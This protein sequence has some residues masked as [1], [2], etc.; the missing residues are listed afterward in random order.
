MTWT[1]TPTNATFT[2]Q[3]TSSLL[4]PIDWVDYIQVPAT[5]S[6]T[7]L[8]LC[9]LSPPSGM[10]L[11]PAGAFTMGDTFSDGSVAERLDGKEVSWTYFG[12]L[13]VRPAVGR[14]FTARDGQ[15][16][17]PPAVIEPCGATKCGRS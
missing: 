7:T 8:Q 6:I 1:N 10:A 17:S 16:G 12:T 13:G 15:P 11:I 3:T 9:D 2:V 4:S 14:D 5:N